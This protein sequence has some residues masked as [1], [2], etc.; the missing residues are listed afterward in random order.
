MKKIL[1][2]S[3]GYYPDHVGGAEVAVKEITKRL[4]DKYEFDL[5]TLSCG[6]GAACCKSYEVIDGVN[7]HRVSSIIGGLADTFFGKQSSAGDFALLSKVIYPVWAF[8]YGAWLNRSRGYDTVWSI[9]AAHAGLAGLIYKLFHPGVR[10]VL[11]LQEGLSAAEME[12]KASMIWYLYKMI[13][14]EADAIHALS[15]YLADFAH[16]NVGVKKPIEVIPN[17]VDYEKFSVTLNS[18]D[19]NSIRSNYG[20]TAGDFVLVT[21]SRLVPKNGVEYIIE[22]LGL[23]VQPA[24]PEVKLLIIGQGF[25]EQQLKQKV[26]ELKLD[27]RV[28]FAGFVDNDSLPKIL[29]SCDAFVR[30]SLSEGF[31]VSFVEAMA[32][33]IP[34]IAT[35]VGGIKDFLVDP[36]QDHSSD[37]TLATGL[38]CL[39]SDSASIAAAVY[40]LRHDRALSLRLVNNA[41]Q[42]VKTRYDWKVIVSSISRILEKN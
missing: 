21:T 3:L 36:S 26:N 23:N 1:I 42:M 28:K 18:E 38:A 22:S 6:R 2:F 17:G 14:N 24:S 12:R 40:K 8:V 15:K 11:N 16:N 5:V 41:R 25:L 32:A 7:V 31:G 33:G 13:F 9:M 39:P 20:F 29:A 4:S 37:G 19:R 27:E 30:P 34:V 10:Y 35:Q